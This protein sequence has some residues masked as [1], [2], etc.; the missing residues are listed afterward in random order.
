[1]HQLFLRRFCLTLALCCFWMADSSVVYAQEHSTLTI[2]TRNQEEIR[3]AIDKKLFSRT[4]QQLTIGNIPPGKHRVQVYKARIP[5]Q[6]RASLLYDGYIRIVPGKHFDLLVSPASATL[7]TRRRNGPDAPSGRSISAADDMHLYEDSNGD[8]EANEE[9]VP[10]AGATDL[11]VQKLDELSSLAASQET[12]T[13][14][15]RVLKRELRHKKINAAQAAGM[16]EWFVT[17]LIRLEFA[18]WAYPYISDPEN[19]A[20]LKKEFLFDASREEWE[21][22]LKR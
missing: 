9:H 18:K 21:E 14:K 19:G 10:P 2:A 1:M 3:V 7:N 15:L 5:T 13:A 11:T 17:D 16:M 8:S 4:G 12:D 20:R 6:D 22:W